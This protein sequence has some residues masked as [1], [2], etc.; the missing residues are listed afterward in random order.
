MSRAVPASDPRLHVLHP[1]DMVIHSMLHGFYNGEF[2]NCFRDVLDV[3]ELLSHW[4]EHHPGFWPELGARAAGMG[5]ERPV[6]YALRYA[7]RLLG[8][9]VPADVVAHFARHAPGRVAARLMDFSVTTTYQPPL[10]PTPR[11]RLA[12]RLMQ[13][14][15]HWIKMP[16]LLL[17]RH[18][19]R[20]LA[21][22]I[23]EGRAADDIVG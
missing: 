7:R 18:L 1:V 15:A 17:A 12:W 8:T 13:V 11:V 6:H 3:H 16:P 19:A 23:A 9:P 22:R 5:I 21:R 2:T 4:S 10:V 20:K 14:R